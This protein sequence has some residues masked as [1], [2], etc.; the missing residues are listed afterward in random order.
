M[1]RLTRVAA[2]NRRWSVR[3]VAGLGAVWALCWVFGAQLVSHTPIASTLSAGLIVDQVHALQA[4]IHDRGV[5]AKQIN[6]DPYRN[7]PTNQLLTDLRGKDVLLVFVE[8]YGQQ[9]VQG[10]SFSPEVDAALAQGEQATEGRGLLSPERLPHL[11]DIWRHQLA[12]ALEPAVG[13]LG[14]QPAP[15]QPAD[16]GKPLHARRG[17]QA[18]RVADSRRCAIER[19]RLAAGSELLPLRQDLQPLPGRLSRPHV[20]LRVDARPVHLLGAPAP[21]ARQEP[22]Q[23]AVRGGRHRVEPHAVEPHP[24][25]DRLEAGRQRVDLQQD[26][27]D[28]RDGRVLEQL[29]HA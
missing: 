7:T 29:P 5:F 19:P 20:H 4:D 3:V 17:V 1:L 22:P 15:L 8:A 13:A 6:N 25:S 14:G 10:T 24:P 28:P 27:D 26:S 2:A 21:R 18:G 9:A 11:G 16:V 12:G 23:A